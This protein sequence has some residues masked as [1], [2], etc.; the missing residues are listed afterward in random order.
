M[1]GLVKAIAWGCIMICVAL[2][3]TGVFLF[4][5]IRSV[6]GYNEEEES[7]E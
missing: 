4:Y 5:I 7:I 1:A 6:F 2:I 3:G